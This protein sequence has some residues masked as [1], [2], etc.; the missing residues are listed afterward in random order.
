MGWVGRGW[1]RYMYVHGCGQRL[2]EWRGDWLAPG[3]AMP[4]FRYIATSF[5]W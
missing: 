2:G 3:F 5:Y 4:G 1:G